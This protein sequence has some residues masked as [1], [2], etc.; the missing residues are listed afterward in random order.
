M[1]ADRSANGT[2]VPMTATATRAGARSA[3]A[4]HGFTALQTRATATEVVESF[5]E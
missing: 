3:A 1:I 2:Y 5:C 4:R